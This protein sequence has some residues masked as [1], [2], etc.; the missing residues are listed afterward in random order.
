MS[1]DL[2]NPQWEKRPR[3]NYVAV[4]SNGKIAIRSSHRDMYA[5]ASVCINRSDQQFIYWCSF[6]RNKELA[7]RNTKWGNNHYG[8]QGYLYETIELQRVTRQEFAKLSR[9]RLKEIREYREQY[10][11]EQLIELHNTHL[12]IT[13]IGGN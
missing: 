10:Y 7:D 4:A 13:T 1:N 6:H 8:E 11:Q 3:T 12:Q 5:Y 9:M 2:L